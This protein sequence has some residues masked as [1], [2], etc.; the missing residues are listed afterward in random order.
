MLKSLWSISFLSGVFGLI[1]LPEKQQ[2][3]LKS[4]TYAPS[5]LPAIPLAVKS[6]Y[7]SAW[8][9]A[10]SEGGNGGKLFGSWPVHWR[11]VSSTLF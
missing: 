10:G 2:I 8:L 9:K 7:L 3:A 5:R 6:P 11:F 1:S 4:S